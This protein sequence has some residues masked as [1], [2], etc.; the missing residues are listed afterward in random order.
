[1]LIQSANEVFKMAGFR[2]FD[3]IHLSWLVV[4]LIF[5]LVNCYMY[6]MGSIG[7]RLHW[8]KIIFWALFII[9]IIKQLY[10]AITDQYTFWS[11]PLH[12]CGFGIFIIG[13]HVYYANR[14][15]STLLFALTLPGAVIALIFPGWTTDPVG[16]FLHVHSFLFHAL[17][18]VYVVS[19]LISNELQVKF[20]DLWRAVVFLLATVP[21]IYFYNNSFNT[22][23]MFLNQPVRGT[24]LQWLYDGVGAGGYI[25]SLIVVLILLW[26]AMYS[27][28]NIVLIISRNDS[29]KK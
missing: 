18:I 12:L 2:I 10:L 13:I 24:P 25:G 3:A 9:E 8:Q 27:V 23:F 22:N 6:K 14:T 7:W 19:L 21:I 5:I 26:I 17:L 15:T 28:K 20:Y 11:P 16:G 4:I 1:M 29:I